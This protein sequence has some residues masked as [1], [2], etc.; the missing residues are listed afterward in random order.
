MT[1][2][3]LGFIMK[4]TEEKKKLLLAAYTDKLKSFGE[5]CK[6][7]GISRQTAYNWLETEGVEIKSNRGCRTKSGRFA[8]EN[9]VSL[10]T[11][12]KYIAAQERYEKEGVI[13]SVGLKE[14][15]IGTNKQKEVEKVLRSF[16]LVLQDMG[17]RYKDS[18]MSLT[19][20]EV[21]ELFREPTTTL[22]RILK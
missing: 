5:T 22:R 14:L 11:A 15:G 21:I 12:R 19:A 18:K 6:E 2:K 16:G 9:G 17:L 7:I 8:R 3:Q 10:P 13:D 4:K 20:A 1:S